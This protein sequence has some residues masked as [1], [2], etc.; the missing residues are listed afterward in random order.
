VI[1]PDGCAVELYALLPPGGEPEIVHGAVP[2]GASILELGAGTG[3]M[4]HPLLELRA[5][6]ERDQHWVVL[7]DPEGN[8]FCLY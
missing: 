3:R 5:H 1:T 6:D 8:E 7:Q 4:T 2:E